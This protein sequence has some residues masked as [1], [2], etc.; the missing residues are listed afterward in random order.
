MRCLVCLLEEPSAKE[1]LKGVL[2]RMLPDDVKI[3]YIIFE[4]NSWQGQS[5]HGQPT[6]EGAAGGIGRAS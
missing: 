6:L 5:R 1:M 4:G 2:P 3:T